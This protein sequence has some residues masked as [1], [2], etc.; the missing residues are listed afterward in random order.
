MGEVHHQQFA[1]IQH[2]LEVIKR[3]EEEKLF[4]VVVPIGPHAPKRPGAVVQGV[5]HDADLRLF[6]GNN[7]ALKICIRRSLGHN[8]SPKFYLP[9]VSSIIPILLAVPR[10]M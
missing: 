7:L 6:N 2:A 10:T 1:G 9:L 8:V 4:V 5:G 3:A